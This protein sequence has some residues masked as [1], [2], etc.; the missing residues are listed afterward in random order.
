LDS[1]LEQLDGRQV[2]LLNGSQVVLQTHGVEV[3]KLDMSTIERFLDAISDP[4]IAYILLS[5]AMLGLF[6]ELANP[7]MVFP[8]VLGGIFLFLS[9]YS[10]G[11]LQL[12]P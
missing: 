8:G 7:G 6:V 1:L 4:N 9:L 11:M 10:L 12:Q 3:R 5:L 2:R